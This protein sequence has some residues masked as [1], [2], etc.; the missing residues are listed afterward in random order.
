MGSGRHLR[1]LRYPLRCGGLLRWNL[2]ASMSEV[3]QLRSLAASCTCPLSAHRVV[4]I[5]RSCH[6]LALLQVDEMLS[7]DL[8]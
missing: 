8:A 2:D 1:H 6:L 5:D 7:F 3:V 4:N